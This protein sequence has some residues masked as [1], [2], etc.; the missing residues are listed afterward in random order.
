MSVKGCTGKGY[1]GQSNLDLEDSDVGERAT[2]HSR[3]GDIPIYP[4]IMVLRYTFLP[5]I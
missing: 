4:Q 5:D 1:L 3:L 2:T